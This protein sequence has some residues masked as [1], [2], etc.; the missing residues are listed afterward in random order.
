MKPHG[1]LGAFY[2]NKF[3]QSDLRARS[4][5][6]QRPPRI[7]APRRVVKSQ[8]KQIIDDFFLF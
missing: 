8:A 6:G 1:Y 3:V 5:R 2:Q 4:A 7:V